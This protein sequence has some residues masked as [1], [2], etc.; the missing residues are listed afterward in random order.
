M[1]Y[2]INRINKN[3]FRELNHETAFILGYIFTDG[4]LLYEKSRD[5][6]FLR[7]YSK[8]RV[9]LENTKKVLRAKAKIQY[10]EEKNY[11]GTKQGA[12]F[13]IH[14][15]TPEI[16]Q[17]LRDL[18]LT[19]KKNINLKFPKIAKK[20]IPAFIRGCWM[21]SG[22]VSLYKNT[23]MSSI[24]IGSLDFINE[25]EIHLHNIGLTKRK[26]YK[27]ENSKRPSYLIKYA[28]KD[29]DKLQKYIYKNHTETTMCKRQKELYKNKY[30]I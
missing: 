16:I 22:C 7:I 9:Q 3:S 20:Y 2:K 28:T 29:S 5:K 18:G 25:M 4:D 24:T 8:Y 23:L 10:R 26:I 14:I 17:D 19:L 11:G 15:E 21:G 13:W 6:Y 30:E 1:A 12:I 27:L